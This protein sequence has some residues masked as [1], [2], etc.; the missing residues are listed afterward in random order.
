MYKEYYVTFPGGFRL[1]LALAVDTISQ[2]RWENNV[3]PVLEAE[4]EA[5]ARNYLLGQ[6]QAGTVLSAEEMFSKEAGVYLFQGKYI[7]R[8]MIGRERQ[9]TIGD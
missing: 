9:E 3:Q 7:C 2:Y 5:Y 4:I 1:P 8:E 6:I